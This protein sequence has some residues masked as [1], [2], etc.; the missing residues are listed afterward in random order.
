MSKPVLADGESV[1]I[2]LM[3]GY[4]TEQFELN[5]TADALR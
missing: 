1:T 3:D 2:P 4:F 5:D